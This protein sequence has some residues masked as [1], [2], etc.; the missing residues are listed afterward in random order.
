VSQENVELVRAIYEGWLCGEM[1]LDR[2]DPEIAMFESTT[3]PGAASAV[4]ID[5]VRQYME[6]FAK[7]WDEIRFE[8]GEYI[9][10]GDRVVVIARLVGR[11]KASGVTVERTWAYVWTLREQRILRMDGYENRREALEAVGLAD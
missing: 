11:G 5:A 6:S 1:G 7:Y 3:L 8:P 10:A 2:F 4:G 9:D